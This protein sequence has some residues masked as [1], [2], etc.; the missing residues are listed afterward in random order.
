MSYLYIFFQIKMSKIKTSGHEITL[1][2]R[3][4]DKNKIVH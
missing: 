1:S 4:H 2:E 3:E